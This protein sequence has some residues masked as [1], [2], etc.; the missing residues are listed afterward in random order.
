M[1]R[2]SDGTIESET[3]LLAGQEVARL[4]KQIDAMARINEAQAATIKQQDAALAQAMRDLEIARL[5]IKSM[6]A[7]IARLQAVRQ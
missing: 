5:A 6:G 7:A 1:K 4:R 2:N 3:G